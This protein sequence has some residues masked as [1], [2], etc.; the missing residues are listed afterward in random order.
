MTEFYRF[1]S[2]EKLLEEPFRELERQTV[3]FATLEDLNDPMEGFQDL[4]WSG[5]HII[6]LNLLKNY[7]HCLRWTCINALVFGNE[8]NLEPGHIPVRLR[9]DT[10]PTPKAVE[11]FDVVW[12]KVRDECELE[13][14]AEGIAGLEYSGIKHKVRRAE[15]L[16]YLWS[17][18]IR[19]LSAVQHALA[20]CGLM[21]E[22][23]RFPLNS[24]RERAFTTQGYF[25]SVKRAPENANPMSEYMFSLSESIFRNLTV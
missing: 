25:D 20:T 1:R 5:D 13:A 24:S 19:A 18:H 9:W 21:T 16:F 22:S 2:I 15:L 8:Y 14:L 3:F 6:W 17:I 4:V 23:Q 7:V 12:G 11:L 10:E